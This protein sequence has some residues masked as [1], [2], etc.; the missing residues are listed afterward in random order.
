MSAKF[1][2]E[3]PKRIIKAL[4]LKD[5][6][7][8]EVDGRPYSLS[9]LTG[10]PV[11]IHPSRAHIHLEAGKTIVDQNYDGLI[12]AGFDG[13]RRSA[14][15]QRGIKRWWTEFLCEGERK[16][17]GEIVSPY[18]ASLEATELASLVLENHTTK[19]KGFY[20][21]ADL[22]SSII[23][24]KFCVKHIGGYIT[25]LQA[26]LLRELSVVSPIKKILGVCFMNNGREVAG[27]D[28]YIKHLNSGKFARRYKAVEGV[29]FPLAERCKGI[30]EELEKQERKKDLKATAAAFE[31][32]ESEP[33]DDEE[34]PPTTDV[35]PPEI[36]PAS[37]SDPS[38]GRLIMESMK[39]KTYFT[40]THN[41]LD[42][43]FSLLCGMV[44]MIDPSK[45]YVRIFINPKIYADQPEFL[46]VIANLGE[47]EDEK[48]KFKKFYKWI[49]DQ[50]PNT[51][52]QIRRWWNKK[53]TEVQRTRLELTFNSLKFDSGPAF[54]SPKVQGGHWT[55]GRF[56]RA[57]LMPYVM[58]AAADHIPGYNES[59]E[60][61]ILQSHMFKKNIFPA[62][63]ELLFVKKNEDVPTCVGV[64]AP[65][66]ANAK[67]S[68]VLSQARNTGKEGEEKAF[69]DLVRCFTQFGEV[70]KTAD[71]VRNSG[72]F[73]QHLKDGHFI[74]FEIKNQAKPPSST[75][76]FTKLYNDIKITS[77]IVPK[78]PVAVIISMRSSFPGQGLVV[79]SFPSPD[80]NTLIVCI[81]NVAVSHTKDYDPYQVAAE[82]VRKSLTDCKLL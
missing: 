70:R 68:A 34:S 13:Y 37:D 12:E 51:T 30:R 45:L 7:T 55:D 21:R 42:Y 61:K 69:P 79:E 46:E 26:T 36:S 35:I 64:P 80:E 38:Q 16:E 73:I 52:A 66:I 32:D 24:S 27:Q 76:S 17:L 23:N 59:E 50:G 33:S 67:K 81:N 9:V 49:D 18:D 72:D 56:W 6:F 71:H 31:A 43:T 48:I 15:I 74:L 82:L 20:W 5:V 63:A 65:R 77:G 58:S 14:Q 4:D 2:A 29:D 57:D 22:L 11:I 75:N 10:M 53:L 8:A 54:I 78:C 47:T 19:Y 25:S 40:M 1:I 62:L 28:I 60:K 39:F 3:R 41:N 44:V